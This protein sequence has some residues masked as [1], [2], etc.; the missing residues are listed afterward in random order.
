[1]NEQKVGELQIQAAC[2]ASLEALLLTWNCTT[3]GSV[4][5]LWG[6]EEVGEPPRQALDQILHSGDKPG[7]DLCP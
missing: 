7:A 3:R 2:Q 4:S 6:G 1:M 5:T